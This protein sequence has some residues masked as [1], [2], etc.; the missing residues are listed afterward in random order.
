[1]F[2]SC[3]VSVMYT[4]PVMRHTH[5]LICT[6]THTPLRES[7]VHTRSHTSRHT[8]THVH[9][10]THIET[11][12]THTHTPLLS[13]P[14]KYLCLL[15]KDW[16]FSR[17]HRLVNNRTARNRPVPTI[18]V[19]VC[20]CVYWQNKSAVSAVDLSL[21]LFFPCLS[22]CA[23]LLCYGGFKGH[24][25]PSLWY[26]IGLSNDDDMHIRKIAH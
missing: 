21:L 6:C 12:Q 23:E 15:E 10:L 20:A 7:A 19:F 2:L 25:V 13:V 24:A 8:H 26:T 17:I 1:M 22:H 14:G 18:C 16:R 4:L 5:T 3:A 11:H 9:M